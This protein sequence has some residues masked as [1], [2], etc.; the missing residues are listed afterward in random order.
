MCPHKDWNG[1]TANGFWRPK[2][3]DGYLRKEHEDVVE[4]GVN[5]AAKATMLTRQQRD[6]PKCCEMWKATAERKL[7]SFAL[8]GGITFWITHL[9][10][11]LGFVLIANS[12]PESY[13]HPMVEWLDPPQIG[14]IESDADTSH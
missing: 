3:I 8:I 10:G 9:T 4:E 11:A 13:G 6:V 1:T 7:E 12:V 5:Q 2:N 14:F